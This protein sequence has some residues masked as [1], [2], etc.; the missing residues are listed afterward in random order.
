MKGVGIATQYI[1]GKVFLAAGGTAVPGKTIAAELLGGLLGCRAFVVHW[2]AIELGGS[3]S[4]I[5]PM[6]RVC[7]ALV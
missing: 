1:V 2:R 4:A 7:A 6:S 3:F 5:N